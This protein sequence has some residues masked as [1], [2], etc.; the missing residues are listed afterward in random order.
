MYSS[1]TAPN[2]FL[3][4]VSD[5]DFVQLLLLRRVFAVGKQLASSSRFVRAAASGTLGE[6]SETEHL[7]LADKTVAE[8]PELAA[9]GVG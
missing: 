4:A 3:A 8:A 6:R 7:L 5:R 9:G 1:A 2:V